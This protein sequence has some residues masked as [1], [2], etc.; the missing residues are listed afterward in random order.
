MYS[1][2]VWQISIR[3]QIRLDHQTFQKYPPIRY[4]FQ[5]GNYRQT[6]QPNELWFIC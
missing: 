6:D 5:P 3:E 2:A 1:S 4:I